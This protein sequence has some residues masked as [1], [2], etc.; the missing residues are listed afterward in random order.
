MRI[1]KFLWCVRSYKTRSI[2]TEACRTGRVRWM[3]Q[4]VKASHEVKVG[5]VIAIREAPIWRSFRILSIPAS[6]VGAKLVPELIEEVT[7]WEDLQKREI[8]RKVKTAHR[9]PGSGRP[10]K[11]DRRSI[12]RLRERGDA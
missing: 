10:T 9:E 6:R 11:R 3:D 12:D 7:L 5:D 2:A 1:D 8:A 4:T